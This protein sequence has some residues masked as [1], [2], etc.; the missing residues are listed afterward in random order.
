MLRFTLRRLLL[1]P[2]ALIVMN[3]LGF[4]FAYVIAQFQRSQTI[5]GSGQEQLDPVWP[6]YVEYAQQALKLDFG[7]MPIGIDVPIAS[8]VAAATLNSLALL[9]LAF[10]LSIAL[11][12]LIGLSAVWVDPPK[13]AGWLSVISTVGLAMPGFYV[14]TLFVGAMIMS[15]YGSDRQPLL[16]VAGFGFDQHLILPV[17]ALAI[18]PC[19]QVAQVSGSLLADELGKR[20]VVAGRAFGQTWHDMRWNKALRNVLAPIFLTIASSFRLLMAE[21]LLVEWLFNWPGL[22]RLLALT[23][24]PPRFS[25]VGGLLDT[26]VYFLDPPLVAALL[27]VFGLLFLLAD[28]IASGLARASDPRLRLAEE[29]H[30]NG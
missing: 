6:A 21:L 7:S 29:E 9:G 12:L 11:G 30:F 4:S 20:Y 2:L 16:P 17:L 18:R 8:A 28:S 27:V 24:V 10:V 19:V 22:G 14:G 3:F 23:L 5:Y 1:I 25:S 13:T 26:S 15:T